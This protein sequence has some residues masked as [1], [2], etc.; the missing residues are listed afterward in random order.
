L[1]DGVIRKAGVSGLRSGEE[2][3]FLIGVRGGV[4]GGKGKSFVIG[5]ADAF[6]DDEV[7]RSCVSKFVNLA[8]DVI[9]F[10]GTGGDN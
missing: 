1:V 7:S 9:F 6:T 8:A 10:D 5:T 2:K 4:C 3:I